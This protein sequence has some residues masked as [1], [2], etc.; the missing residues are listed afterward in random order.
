MLTNTENPI[1][2]EHA[3]FKMGDHGP[4]IDHI[5][6]GAKD[7]EKAAA[8]IFQ[9]GSGTKVTCMLSKYRK[10]RDEKA[11]VHWTAPILSVD[12]AVCTFRGFLPGIKNHE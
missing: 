1:L 2:T 4:R 12:L 7:V 6:I 5:I 10:T 11:L 3:L 9:V 8:H